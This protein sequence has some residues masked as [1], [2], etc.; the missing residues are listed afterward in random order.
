MR[1]LLCAC[2]CGWLPQRVQC[3]SGVG[4]AGFARHCCPELEEA[5]PEYCRGQLPMSAQVKE[6]A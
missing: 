2:L 3:T 4:L 6:W 5:A 1:T